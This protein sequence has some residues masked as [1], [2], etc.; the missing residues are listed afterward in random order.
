[1]DIK[2]LDKIKNMDNNCNEEIR[3]TGL[4]FNNK[5]DTRPSS[6]TEQLSYDFIKKL[7]REHDENAD[8]G[9]TGLDF[10]NKGNLSGASAEVT[11][12]DFISRE[13]EH[14][15]D[16]ASPEGLDSIRQIDFSEMGIIR[17]ED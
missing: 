6:G 8:H 16:D 11:G 3:V 14:G 17:H 12:L 1:M 7:D 9:V 4:D 2:G 15:V 5:Q 13:R 10:I